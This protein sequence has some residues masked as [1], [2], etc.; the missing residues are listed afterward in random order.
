MYKLPMMYMGV[1]SKVIKP[2]DSASM[3]K[4]QY[5]YEVEMALDGGML[6][7]YRCICVDGQFGSPFDFEDQVLDK[8][9]RVF[10]MF[11]RGLPQLGII[12]G[13]SRKSNVKEKVEGNGPRYLK[14]LRETEQE[15]TSDGEYSIRTLTKS[16]GPTASEIQLTK[17]QLVI[18]SNKDKSTNTITLDQDDVSITVKTGTLTI[19]VENNSKIAINGNATLDVK[20]DITINCSDAKIKA[21]NIKADVKNATVKASQNVKVE[22]MKVTLAGDE[23]QVLTTMTQPTCYVTGAPFKGSTK[24]F[25]GS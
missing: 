19:T 15:V 9:Y 24:V 21:D 2:T 4:Y 1:I 10:V 13:G 18:T 6:Q 8:N 5:E 25:A 7:T 3:T 16:D 12:I 23:G 11:P 20:G 17:T 22:A 14:H